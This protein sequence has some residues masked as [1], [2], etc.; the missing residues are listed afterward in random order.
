MIYDNQKKSLIKAILF[1]K[2]LRLRRDLRNDFSPS[3]F[4]DIDIISVC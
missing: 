2:E 3:G 1:E 4:D